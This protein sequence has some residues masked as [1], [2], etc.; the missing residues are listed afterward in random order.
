[1][2]EL[3]IPES[4]TETEFGSI[5]KAIKGKKPK[6]LF[7]SN[8]EGDLVPYV[9]IKAFS[10]GIIRNYAKVEESRI[11]EDRD[12]VIVWDGS[13]SGLVGYSL[14]GSLGSTLG[15]YPKNKNIDNN[16]FYHFLNSKYPLLNKNTKGAGIPHL[17]PDYLNKFFFPLPPLK[18]QERIV[19]KIESCFE[20]IN[21]TEQSLTKIENLL[22]R[23]RESILAKA[24][25]GK[26]IP[27]RKSDEPTSILLEKICAEREMSAPAKKKKVQAF[28]SIIDDDKPFDIP[29]SWEWVK[30]EDV[31]DFITKGTTPTKNEMRLGQLEIPFIKVHNLT[32]TG[33]LN[34]TDKTAFIPETVHNGK[35]ARS[36]VYPEDVLMN[37]VGPPMGKVSIVTSEYPEWNVNQA[38]A[39]F[40]P[41]NG[42]DSKYLSMLLMSPEILSDSI[43]KGKRTAG[44]FNFTLEICRDILLPLPPMEEQLRISKLYNNQINKIKIIADKILL[45]KKFLEDMNS[46]ILQKAFEGQLVEQIESEGTGQELLGKILATKE[47]E[48]PVK[49][50]KKKIVKEMTS[51]KK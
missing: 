20:K 34:F 49:K 43:R 27:Q 40:R 36:K 15:R 23:Y 48:K 29:E 19:K 7:T 30:A 26:L 51:K 10:K 32:F 14:F 44:Q 21:A 24:F 2:S 46:S 47:A 37:I 4:W 35:L 28:A 18:E 8:E 6:S 39:I 42:I 3:N 25:S 11:V 22:E 13:R 33:Q 9:D 31:C 45:S 41:V 1:M 17:N 5:F 12:V 16:Y 50:I 38:I